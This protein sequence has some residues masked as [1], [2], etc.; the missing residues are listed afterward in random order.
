MDRIARLLALLVI[1]DTDDKAEQALML[2]GAGFGETEITK[3]LGVNSSYL[4]TV[5]HRRKRRPRKSS[6]K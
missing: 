1:K 2:D 6:R 5:R 3:M 4:R